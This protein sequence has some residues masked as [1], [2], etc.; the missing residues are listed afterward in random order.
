MVGIVEL[1][2]PSKEEGKDPF[3]FIE[4]ICELGSGTI[5]SC[6]TYL[7]HTLTYRTDGYTYICIFHVRARKHDQLDHANPESLSNSNTYD[8]C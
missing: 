2:A 7:C 1:S 8:F 3:V 6:R 5:G 4:G